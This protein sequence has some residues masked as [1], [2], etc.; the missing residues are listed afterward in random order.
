MAKISVIVPIYNA[1]KYLAECIDSLI[2]QKHR[3]LQILLI[4]DGS[5]DNSLTIAQDF[6]QRDP[7]IEIY[8]QPNQ[9]QG[10]ARNNAMKYAT[11]EWIAF[12]DADDYIAPNLYSDILPLANKADVVVHGYQRVSSTGKLISLHF[13]HHFKYTTPWVRIFRREWLEKNAITFPERMCYEDVIFTIDHWIARPNYIVVKHTGYSYR[14]HESSTTAISHE[15]D[16]KRL[17]QLLCHR[18][19]SVDTCVDKILI[20]YTIIRLKLHFMLYD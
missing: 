19:K 20:I 14:L 17:F 18:L 13:P 8:S 12:V 6:A 16:Q 15:E 4:N 2:H 3:D 10:A 1:E 11:G 9:G 5:T 7:R